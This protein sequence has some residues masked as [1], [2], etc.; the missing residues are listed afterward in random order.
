MQE[1]VINTIVRS[2]S[3]RINERFRVSFM[4]TRKVF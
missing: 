2:S 4:T 1:Q 3:V